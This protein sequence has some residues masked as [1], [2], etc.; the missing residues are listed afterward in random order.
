MEVDREVVAPVSAAE[1]SMAPE[2]V[3]LTAQRL[4]EVTEERERWILKRVEVQKRKERLVKL[5]QLQG[6]SQHKNQQIEAQKSNTNVKP[7]SK[8]DNR[9]TNE[10]AAVQ[11]RKKELKE[12]QARAEVAKEVRWTIL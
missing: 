4:K 9:S 3:Q 7:M 6:A 5:L 8:G 12:L 1:G 11:T 2:A 10:A